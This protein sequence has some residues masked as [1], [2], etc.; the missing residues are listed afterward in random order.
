MGLCKKS[1]DLVSGIGRGWDNLWFV[2]QNR[3]SVS[4]DS[5]VQNT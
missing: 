2:M 5:V 3:R 1:R 4:L